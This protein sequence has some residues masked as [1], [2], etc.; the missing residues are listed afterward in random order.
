R[1]AFADVGCA[2]C[3]RRHPMLVLP[4]TIANNYGEAV[5]TCG[6]ET[7]QH[8]MTTPPC[9]QRA[10]PH[11]LSV[12]MVSPIPWYGMRLGIA[13]AGRNLTARCRALQP[14]GPASSR[15]WRPICA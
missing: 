15:I 11:N 2:D 12:V 6:I 5:E 10:T 9:G 4:A 1:P 13:P 14:S 3:H 7:D 8:R